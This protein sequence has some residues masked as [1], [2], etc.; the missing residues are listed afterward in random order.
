VEELGSELEELER[1]PQ[2]QWESELELELE[3]D[4]SRKS[5]TIGKR[6]DS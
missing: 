3:L 4:D 2:Q 5:M 6:R 1:K